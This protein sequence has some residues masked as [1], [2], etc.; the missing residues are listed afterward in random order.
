MAVASISNVISAD[1][2]GA[3]QGKSQRSPLALNTQLLASNR[4]GVTGLP[5]GASARTPVT[6]A[7]LST[8]AAVDPGAGNRSSITTLV[9]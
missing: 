7:P 6:V 2:P 4:L 3:S 5:L 8:K 9:A 1:S